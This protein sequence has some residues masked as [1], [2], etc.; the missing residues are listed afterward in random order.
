MT[1]TPNGRLPL[2]RGET[3][4]IVPLDGPP[5]G[6]I[7]G[8]V[9]DLGNEGVPAT[10]SVP[11]ALP[12][13][14]FDRARGQYRAER[15]LALARGLDGRRVLAVTAHDL[16]AEGLNFVFGTADSPGRAAVI[17]LARLHGGA[18]AATFRARAV[19][20]AIHELGHTLGLGHC[21]NPRCVM[22]FSNSLADTDRKTARLCDACLLAASRRVRAR[23]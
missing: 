1:A 3:V 20:E 21:A 11:A 22:R 13:S 17:S 15:L 6:E 9:V 16:Y 18:D 10:L 5:A 19:K 8:L 4:S 12:S 14:A 23:S 7:V 2:P